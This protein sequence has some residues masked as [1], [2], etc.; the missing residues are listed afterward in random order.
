MA[1]EAE[2]LP[3]SPQSN[4]VKELQPTPETRQSVIGRLIGKLR[5]LVGPTLDHIG[6][7]EAHETLGPWSATKK[8]LFEKQVSQKKLPESGKP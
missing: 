4:I 5:G 7:G 6:S 2:E 3:S 1:G 8:E